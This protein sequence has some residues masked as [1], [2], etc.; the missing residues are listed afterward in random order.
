MSFFKAIPTNSFLSKKA[1]WNEKSRV[2]YKYQ[3]V[4]QLCKLGL[5]QTHQLQQMEDLWI[6]ESITYFRHLQDGIGI[7]YFAHLNVAIKQLLKGG[8]SE[9]N[10]I[11]TSLAL[12]Q[13]TSSFSSKKRS[14]VNSWNSPL[15]KQQQSYSIRPI[16]IPFLFNQHG[17]A[18]VKFLS[19]VE[20]SSSGNRTRYLFHQRQL[21]RPLNHGRLPDRLTGI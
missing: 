21:R 17:C 1:S 8:K 9:T 15:K 18:C 4:G 16:S 12:K 3:F 7:P 13:M 2:G 20:G 10:T 14:Y 5:L 6:N 11:M 19:L